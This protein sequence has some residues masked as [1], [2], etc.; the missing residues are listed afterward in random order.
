MCAL[1]VGT[2]PMAAILVP[3]FRSDPRFNLFLVGKGN[4]GVHKM[5]VLASS[6]GGSLEHARKQISAFQADGNILLSLFVLL[7]DPP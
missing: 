3:F 2:R 7:N 6:R 5:E 1:D 4:I